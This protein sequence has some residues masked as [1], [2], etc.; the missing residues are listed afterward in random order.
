MLVYQRVP[1]DGGKWLARSLPNSA[2]F[3]VAYAPWENRG[4]VRG[5]D[6]VTFMVMQAKMGK[7]RWKISMIQGQ[8]NIDECTPNYNKS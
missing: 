8:K 7:R 6:A 3:G 4:V 1:S 2:I 5:P